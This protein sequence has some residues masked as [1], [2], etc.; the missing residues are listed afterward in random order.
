MMRVAKPARLAAHG[1]A[2]AHLIEGYRFARHTAPIRSLLLL[3]GLVSL[4]AMPYT[5]LM[6]SSRTRFCM[7]EL[8][9]WAF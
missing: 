6:P 3:L 4:V 5:V 9:D 2:L 7:V 1:P 8:A